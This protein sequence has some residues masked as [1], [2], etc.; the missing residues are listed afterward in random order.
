MPNASTWRFNSENGIILWECIFAFCR[1]NFLFNV[2]SRRIE[3]ITA[4]DNDEDGGGNEI[5]FN[6]ATKNNVVNAFPCNY[7]TEIVGILPAFVM[8]FL[9]DLF[10]LKL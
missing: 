2:I 1:T 5:E 7:C 9:I 4:A 3:N 10:S 8:S 6:L